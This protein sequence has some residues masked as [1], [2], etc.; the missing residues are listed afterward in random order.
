MDTPNEDEF[1]GSQSNINEINLS[2]LLG[3]KMFIKADYLTSKGAQ[4][5]SGNMKKGGKAAKGLDY[6]TPDTKKTFNHILYTFIQAPIFQYFD[7]KWHIRIETITSSYAIGRV[8][9]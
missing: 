6:L 9:S 5:G 2:N 4:K 3:L 1:C 8:L 7:L